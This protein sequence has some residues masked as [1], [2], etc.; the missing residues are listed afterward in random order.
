M[1]VSV[2]FFVIASLPSVLSG[3]TTTNHGNCWVATLNH[4]SPPPM[5]C[6][7][8]YGDT[9]KGGWHTKPCGGCTFWCVNL[10]MFRT[11][12]L[13]DVDR[14]LR[15]VGN[16][17]WKWPDHCWN[18]C[19]PCLRYAVGMLAPCQ[20]SDA[21]PTRLPTLLLRTLLN[22]CLTRAW[23]RRHDLWPPDPRG[24]MHHGLYAQRLAAVV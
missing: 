21:T 2:L 20:N 18:G 22:R 24:N 7:D 19:E 1:F 10:P 9:L 15:H 8:E 5:S 13:L 17:H 23:R 12:S 11:V 4:T 3:F 6:V 14:G 16:K